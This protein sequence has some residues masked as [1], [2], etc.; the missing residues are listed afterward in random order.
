MT[1]LHVHEPR[2]RIRASSSGFCYVSGTRLYSAALSPLGENSTSDRKPLPMQGPPGYA[3]VAVGSIQHGL[4]ISALDGALY[5]WG[6]ET[7]GEKGDGAFVSNPLTVGQIL[8]PASPEVRFVKVAAGQNHSVALDA[9]GRLWGWG[10]ALQNGH[11]GNRDVPTLIAGL[12]YIIDVTAGLDFSVAIGLDGNAYLFG[13]LGRIVSAVGQHQSSGVIYTLRRDSSAGNEALSRPLVR[14]SAGTSHVMLSDAVGGLWFLGANDFGQCGFNPAS[15]PKVDLV[16]LNTSINSSLLGGFKASGD[17]SFI[18][19]GR[20][21]VF[22]GA[23][24]GIPGWP[25]N[26]YLPAEIERFQTIDEAR[27]TFGSVGGTANCIVWSRADGTVY[28]VGSEKAVAGGNVMA[29]ATVPTGRYNSIDVDLPWDRVQVPGALDLVTSNAADTFFVLRDGNLYAFGENSDGQMGTGGLADNFASPALVTPPGG[30]GAFVDVVAGR[31][32][33]LATS[34][35]ALVYAWG[36]GGKYQLGTGTT[37]DSSTPVNAASFN[38]AGWARKFKHLSASDEFSVVAAGAEGRA[39]GANGSGQCRAAPAASVSLSTFTFTAEDSEGDIVSAPVQIIAAGQA[40]VVCVID[41]NYAWS[42]AWGSNSKGQITDD[43]GVVSSQAPIS[44]NGWGDLFV[45]PSLV[46]GRQS[47]FAYRGGKSYDADP[48]TMLVPT[49]GTDSGVWIWGDATYA[50][51]EVTSD[52][53]PLYGQSVVYGEPLEIDVFAGREIMQVSVGAKHQLAVDLDGRVWAWGDNSY[54]QLGQGDSS[55]YTSVVRVPDLPEITHVAAGDRYSMAMD[56]NGAVYLW[57]NG[58]GLRTLLVSHLPIIPPPGGLDT[59]ADGLPDTWELDSFGNLGQDANG[60]WDGD[61]DRNGLEY[62]RNTRAFDVTSLVTG[63]SLDLV[64]TTEAS[65]SVTSQG[66][67]VVSV[68]VKLPPGFAGPVPSVSFEYNS[69]AGEGNC[70]WGWDLAGVSRITRSGTHPNRDLV[71]D[72]I[73]FD[74]ND[75]FYLDG[76]RMVSSEGVYGGHGATYRTESDIFSRITSVKTSS[77]NVVLGPDYFIVETKAGIKLRY[78]PPDYGNPWVPGS[79]GV[80]TNFD[81]GGKTAHLVWLLTEAIDRTGNKTLYTYIPVRGVLDS[82]ADD[83]IDDPAT[84]TL[85]P[86]VTTGRAQRTRLK[87]ADYLLDKI[88]FGL[89]ES[90][91]EST[92]SFGVVKIDYRVAARPTVKFIRDRPIHN[93]HL[94]SSIKTGVVVGA[95]DPLMLSQGGVRMT[96]YRQYVLNY[97]DSTA[98]GRQ[99]LSSIEERGTNGAALKPLEF[100]YAHPVRLP[101]GRAIGTTG[102]NVWP[103]VPTTG[104][105]PV[106]ILNAATGANNGTRLVDANGDGLI[107]IVRSDGAWLNDPGNPGQNWIATGSFWCPIPLAKSN[108][109]V[110]EQHTTRQKS[111]T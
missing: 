6:V 74:D 98:S 27:Q 33:T 64:G 77:A 25:A 71:F 36:E 43:L 100:A 70:G 5:S 84:T 97:S 35:A 99:L 60:D 73:D 52:F 91:E 62:S 9:G 37:S 72:P 82:L 96:L 24:P 20:Y 18:L 87:P 49:V 95:F 76:K 58:T 42:Q 94:V 2:V 109:T 14:A 108:P 57:G 88:F 85:E 67:A 47:N 105:L 41:S 34:P 19:S 28:S 101:R 68:P 54:G 22:F 65:T 61:G 26:L 78:E 103:W 12:P 7:F 79:G 45:P 69:Q 13:N 39:A 1:E 83:V 106:D 89:N 17:R 81:P 90:N 50:Q 107:D 23:N 66:A 10:K 110:D 102:A 53:S 55:P 59:D 63:R 15:R 21:L 29:Y 30:Q 11:S 46:A 92:A 38:P 3:D 80:P 111:A 16:A 31:N 32:H 8:A 51:P 75:V 86:G 4:A 44:S 56:R 40:H 104:T 48:G 93:A